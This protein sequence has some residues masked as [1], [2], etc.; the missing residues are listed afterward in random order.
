[1][2]TKLRRFLSGEERWVRRYAAR[3]GVD[4]AWL[5]ERRLEGG[6][7]PKRCD[8]DDELCEGW[9]WEDAHDFHA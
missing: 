5:R 9:A 7:V 1:M 6:R 3:S 4:P 2:I 8:C